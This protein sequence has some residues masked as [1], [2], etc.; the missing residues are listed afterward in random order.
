MTL[1]VRWKQRF[2]NFQRALRQL[3]LAMPLKAQ[4]P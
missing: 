1:D 4:C 2:D 3:T